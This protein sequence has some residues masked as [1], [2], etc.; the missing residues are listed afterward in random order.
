MQFKLK[1][2]AKTVWSRRMRGVITDALEYANLHMGLY[3][4]DV[5]VHIK[6]SGDPAITGLCY[7]FGSHLLIVIGGHN[8]LD[9]EIVE[10]L[11]HELTHAVQYA[12]GDL[13]DV[14]EQVVYWRGY[15][16]EGDY[17]NTESMD[18]WDAPWEVD[19]RYQATKYTKTYY[20][21]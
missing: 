5:K 12:E 17:D 13:L 1:V 16:Y 9:E 11:F 20:Q 4:H 3:K 8:M 14:E 7:D 18:Y 2:K 6:L 10:T 19:A 15:N 21:I